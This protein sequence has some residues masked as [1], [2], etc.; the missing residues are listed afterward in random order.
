[1]AHLVLFGAL[2][3]E[4]GS[5]FGSCISFEECM[6][7]TLFELFHLY[8]DYR[9]LPNKGVGGSSMVRSDRLRE[10]LSFPMVVL[11]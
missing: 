1:M 9:N 11:D 4:G 10:R 8:W 2:V 6:C 7:D 3:A 5:V